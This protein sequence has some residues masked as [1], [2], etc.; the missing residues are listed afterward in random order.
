MSINIADINGLTIIPPEL[1]EVYRDNCKLDELTIGC[2]RNQLKLTPKFLV[3]IN[4]KPVKDSNRVIS[5]E[6]EV[7]ILPIIAG[8]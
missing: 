4:K 5:L 7:A 2:L 6:D 8:G 1:L 3:I